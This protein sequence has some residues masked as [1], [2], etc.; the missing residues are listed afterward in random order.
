MVLPVTPW[1]TRDIRVPLPQMKRKKGSTYICGRVSKGNA[2]SLTMPQPLG[3]EVDTGECIDV[4]TMGST[5]I[6]ADQVANQWGY[7]TGGEGSSSSSSKGKKQAAAS[8]TSQ[9]QQLIEQQQPKR[10]QQATGGKQTRH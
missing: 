8:P 7:Y 5:T 4:A 2:S 1:V 9:Q 10:Q 3:Y 6:K